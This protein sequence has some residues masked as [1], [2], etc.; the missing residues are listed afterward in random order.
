[1]QAVGG[2]QL[3]GSAL[4]Y[5]LRLEDTLEPFLGDTVRHVPEVIAVLYTSASVSA[6]AKRVADRL[7][8]K[9]VEMFH[10]RPYPCIKCNVSRRTGERIYHLPFDLQYDRVVIEPERGEV[11]MTTV[12]AA[13]AAGFRRA[14]RWS[15][16]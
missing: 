6:M 11:F 3:F 14:Y 1:V 9:I 16:E 15:G 4:E 5:Q 7:K 8:V 12:A 13:E 10:P 2:F